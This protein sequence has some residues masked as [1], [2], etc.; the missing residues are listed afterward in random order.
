MEWGARQVPCGVERVGRVAGHG[1]RDWRV[2]R[3]GRPNVGLKLAGAGSF[4]PSVECGAALLG[5]ECTWVQR[6][7]ERV[8][9]DCDCVQSC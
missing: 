9:P 7:C 6:G 2:V 4:C 3:S 1:R 8:N 5:R